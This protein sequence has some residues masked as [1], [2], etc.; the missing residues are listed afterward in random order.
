LSFIFRQYTFEWTRLDCTKIRGSTRIWYVHRSEQRK[1]IAI[2][3]V[4]SLKDYH[5]KGLEYH[6]PAFKLSFSEIVALDGGKCRESTPF[7][8]TMEAVGIF[9]LEPSSP[10]H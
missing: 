4:E 7:S 9:V 1:V 8:Y 3:G 6:T 10:R 5:A 2:G